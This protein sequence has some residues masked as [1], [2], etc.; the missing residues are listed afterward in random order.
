MDVDVYN[1][2]L[3]NEYRRKWKYVFKSYLNRKIIWYI[4]FKILY[5]VLNSIFIVM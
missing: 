3:L 4:Y 1:D 5:N 2:I